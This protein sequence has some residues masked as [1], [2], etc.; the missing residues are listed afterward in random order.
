MD[1]LMDGKCQ[2]ECGGD[3]VQIY[4]PI[5]FA[6]RAQHAKVIFP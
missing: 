1:L 4:L 3:T 5:I 2:I 6:S